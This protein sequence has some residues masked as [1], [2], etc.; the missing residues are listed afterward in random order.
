MAKR[1]GR[2]R[3]ALRVPRSVPPREW[4]G[5]LVALGVAIGVEVG[6]RTMTLPRL[7]RIVGAPLHTEGGEMPL[8][9]ASKPPALSPRARRQVRATRRVMRHWPFGDT[10]LRQA[11]VSG[12]RLRRLDPTLWVGVAKLDGQIKAHAWLEI[13]GGCLDPLGGAAS[14]LG[15][16][17]VRR[18]S[19]S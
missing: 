2:L 15:L 17:S 11:L 1:P 14:Y 4:P 9:D 5:V 8:M 16:E 7:A 19:S 13:D 18:G 10:C 3:R 6:L 12:Q